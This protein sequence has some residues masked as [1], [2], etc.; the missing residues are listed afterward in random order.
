MINIEKFKYLDFN[1]SKKQRNNIDCNWLFISGGLKILTNQKHIKEINK[2]GIIHMI[3]QIDGYNYYR[4]TQ[5]LYDQLENELEYKEIELLK[6]YNYSM[7]SNLRTRFNNLLAIKKNKESIQIEHL[8]GG[9]RSLVEKMINSK[10]LEPEHLKTLH[11]NHTLCC[12]KFK[13]EIDINEKVKNLNKIL[14][15]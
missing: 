5:K 11:K 13:S 15:K 12:Y 8:N 10:D 9:I 14:L 6:R 1:L 2:Y 3:R 4:V 7:N